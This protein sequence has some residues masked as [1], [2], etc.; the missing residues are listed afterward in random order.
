MNTKN[1][2]KLCFAIL[3]GIGTAGVSQAAVNNVAVSGPTGGQVPLGTITI[4]A[5]VGSGCDISVSDL[6]FG[7]YD[8]NSGTD[9]VAVGTIDYSCN[10]ITDIGLFITDVGPYFM[11]NGTDDLFY[12]LATGSDPFTNPIWDDGNPYVIS[13]GGLFLGAGSVDYSGAI[14]SGQF[15]SSGIYTHTLTLNVELL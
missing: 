15:V 7:L 3:L 9:T 10:G 5:F 12:F 4:S 6:D 2:N 13:G 14:P 11:N 8:P 1:L